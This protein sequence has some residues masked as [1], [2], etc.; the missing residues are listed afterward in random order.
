M[1]KTFRLISNSVRNNLIEFIKTQVPNNYLVTIQQ[2][3]RT[4]EQNAKMWAILTDF[5]E[6]KPMVING[7]EV[8]A[9]A[10]DWKD[11]LTAGYKKES[12][13]MALGLDKQS[14]VFLGLRTSQMG[15]KEMTEFI[16]FIQAEA[17]N[18][19]VLI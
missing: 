9:S 19:G 2:P 16:E 11:L 17:I 10:E 6:Q 1:R 5:A 4:L 3:T 12:Q 13:R 8:Y 18:N 14:L 7:K 15:V